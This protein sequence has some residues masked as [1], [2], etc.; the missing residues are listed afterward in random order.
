MVHLPCR[1]HPLREP[2]DG[3]ALLTLRARLEIVSD[4]THPQASAAGFAERLHQM[5][6]VNPTPTFSP[7]SRANSEV[8][9]GAPPDIGA[10]YAPASDN[11]TVASLEAR[12]GLQARADAEFEALGTRSSHGRE[13]LDVFTIGKALAMRER[14]VAAG[15]IEGQLNLKTGVVARLGRAGVTTPISSSS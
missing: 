14:G 11:P 1:L 9:P 12:R 2:F 5:G 13:F 3:I 4:S 6:I 10:R 7:S 8:T 15:E